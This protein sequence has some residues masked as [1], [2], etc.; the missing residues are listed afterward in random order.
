MDRN[1]YAA[2]IQL[3]NVPGIGSARVRALVKHFNSAQ[4]AATATINALCQ[5]PGIDRTIAESIRQNT[6]SDFAHRQ[7]QILDR[8][9]H[10][11]VS[12]WDQ[13]YPALLKKT[14]DPPVLLYCNGKFT[15]GD[16][17][18]VAIVGTRGPTQ[19]GKMVAERITAELVARGITIVS[20][21]ARGIDSVVHQAA[22]KNGGRTLAVLG[23]GL[24]IIYPGENRALSQAIAQNGVV[25]S[26]FPFGTKPDAMNFPRRNRIISG[27]SL[28]VVVVEAGRESGAMI[29]ANCALE[30]GREVFAVPGSILSPKSAGP[31]R[32]IQEGAKL[33]SD[34]EDIL[35]EL[36]AQLEL[37]SG[38]S[39]E[40]EPPADLD[41][42]SLAVYNLLSHEPCHA[43]VLMRKTGLSSSQ[44]MVILLELEFRNLVKQL[45]GMFF[46]RAR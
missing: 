32:L 31:H 18:A 5:V 11:L 25:L 21:M 44:T 39:A 43:D 46:V 12:F 29:T 4:T 28:G 6:R 26:E 3:M 16:Q 36:S 2:L 40:Q 42:E 14:P 1:E 24:D 8:L 9:R 17:N 34:V 30:Q 7:L 38:P 35:E 41:K 23:S 20:G 15:A 19:Y 10:A 33:V 27:L 13:S 37:F 45:P 22:I